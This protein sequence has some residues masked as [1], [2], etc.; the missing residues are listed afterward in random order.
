M[1]KIIKEYY[2]SPEPDYDDVN[3][4]EDTALVEAP[5]DAIVVI[6]EKGFYDEKNSV[7]KEPSGKEGFYSDEYYIYICDAD[8]AADY[9][10]ELLFDKYEDFFGEDG[11][12]YKVSGFTSLVFDIENLVECRD[13]FRDRDGDM[14]YD[15]DINTDSM[16]IKFNKKASSISDLK[17]TKL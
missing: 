14:V 7:W 17:V 12:S 10:L 3:Y 1:I 16:E 4:E 9:T 5:I 11:C 15:S 8:D 6:D 2:D 13:Y